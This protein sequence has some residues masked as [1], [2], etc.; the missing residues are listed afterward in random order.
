MALS[1]SGAHD[2]KAEKD[3]CG[4][5]Q[6]LGVAAHFLTLDDSEGKDKGYKNKCV[7]KNDEGRM[8]SYLP[9]DVAPEFYPAA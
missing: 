5:A 2:E 7:S 6:Q 4:D 1:K 8:L 3:H 9:S